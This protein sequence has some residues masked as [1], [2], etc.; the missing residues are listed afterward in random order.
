MVR[1]TS[2]VLRNLFICLNEYINSQSKIF[3]VMHF[4][5]TNINKAQIFDMYS[6]FCIRKQKLQ[7]DIPAVINID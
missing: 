2:I 1:S 4:I 5:E 7:N 6:Y 3:N